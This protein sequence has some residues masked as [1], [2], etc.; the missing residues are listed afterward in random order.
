MKYIF[1]THRTQCELTGRRRDGYY[2]SGTRIHYNVIIYRTDV[3]L[4]VTVNY[5][6][7]YLEVYARTSRVSC[8]RVVAVHVQHPRDV[9]LDK[10]ARRRFTRHKRCSAVVRKA[11]CPQ[12]LHRRSRFVCTLKIKNKSVF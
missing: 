5:N 3:V 1:I 12:S 7:V 2:Y 9:L 11:S 10:R 8:D 6:I 4:H